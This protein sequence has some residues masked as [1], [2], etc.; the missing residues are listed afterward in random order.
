MIAFLGRAIL[1]RVLGRSS[2]RDQVFASLRAAA[3]KTET[4]I[5]DAAVDIIEEAWDVVIPVII[6]KL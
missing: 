6:G 5:D 3:K 2:V 4:K 1:K